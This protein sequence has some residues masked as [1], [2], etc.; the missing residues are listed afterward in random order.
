MYI[1]ITCILNLKFAKG[2]SSVKKLC[3][4]YHRDQEE[5]LGGDEYIYSLDSGDGFNGIKLSPNSTIFIC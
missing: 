5:T 2:K 4:L 3:K 1:P